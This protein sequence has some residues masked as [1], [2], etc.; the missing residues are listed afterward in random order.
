MSTFLSYTETAEE[1][2][3]CTWGMFGWD[4]RS[5]MWV[6]RSPCIY[7]SHPKTYTWPHNDPQTHPQG[8]SDPWAYPRLK[9]TK[10][11]WCSRTRG[12]NRRWQ[13]AAGPH[14][15]TAKPLC[16][17]EHPKPES[18]SL[19]CSLPTCICV[20]VNCSKNFYKIFMLHFPQSFMWVSLL[21]FLFASCYRKFDQD[22]ESVSSGLRRLKH[23]SKAF[24]SLISRD[25]R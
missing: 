24:D 20:F 23:L 3:V 22:L 11:S 14:G 4:P 25:D 13:E 18:V 12:E 8:F 7:L 6:G 17:P 10:D 21:A 1:Q 2:R 5:H 9:N 16:L 19:Q 15:C